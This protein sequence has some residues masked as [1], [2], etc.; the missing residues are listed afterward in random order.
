M[1]KRPTVL[2]DRFQTLQKE[3]QTWRSISNQDGRNY[4]SFK[5]S[6]TCRANMDT[7]GFSWLI[8]FFREAAACLGLQIIK[9][10]KSTIAAEEALQGWINPKMITHGTS[11]CRIRSQICRMLSQSGSSRSWLVAFSVKERKLNRSFCGLYKR[12]RSRALKVDTDEARRKSS[13]LNL[14]SIKGP[15]HGEWYSAKCTLQE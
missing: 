5:W 10:W 6:I 9:K 15:A 1:D 3:N 11:P 4:Q 7:W 8:F 2:H 13:A 12:H 14:L